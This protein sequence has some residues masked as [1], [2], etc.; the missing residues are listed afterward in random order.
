MQSYGPAL[1][2]RLQFFEAFV[3]LSCTVIIN[4]ERTAQ[5]FVLCV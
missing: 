3:F 1:N 5:L 2:A 4:F